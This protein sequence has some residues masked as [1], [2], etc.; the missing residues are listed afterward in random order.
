MSVEDLF[1]EMTTTYVVWHAGAY[2]LAWVALSA[3]AWVHYRRK[4]ASR[5]A[6][7]VTVLHDL[8]RRLAGVSFGVLV[9]WY[10]IPAMWTAHP[11]L[12]IVILLAAVA[13]MATVNERGTGTLDGVG[14]ES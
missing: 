10:L 3:A 7:Q 12:V 13:K 5:P 11:W 9:L 8:A 1:S 4:A 6:P 2:L 14:Q